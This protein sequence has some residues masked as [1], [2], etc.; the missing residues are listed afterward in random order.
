MS[1]M[2]LANCS[3][4]LCL[5]KRKI[6]NLRFI[7]YVFV[8]KCN[9]H[10]ECFALN[11]VNFL[12]IR[13]ISVYSF[14][15]SIF[16]WIK[17]SRCSSANMDK[18]ARVIGEKFD[19]G[20]FLYSKKAEINSPSKKYRDL[21]KLFANRNDFLFINLISSQLQ[22]FRKDLTTAM[23]QI[24]SRNLGWS[25]RFFFVASFQK[26]HLKTPAQSYGA[27]FVRCYSAQT[28]LLLKSEHV[29]S[30]RERRVSNG[31]FYNQMQRILLY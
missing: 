29:C 6:V 21:V 3:V 20:F 31:N 12:Y 2:L 17:N 13:I 18:Y 4:I 27:N 10:V 26:F 19:S 25:K 1:P 24:F 16:C 30:L 15:T 7:R 22:I 8:K 9:N 14:E 5:D 28:N 11:S 23:D